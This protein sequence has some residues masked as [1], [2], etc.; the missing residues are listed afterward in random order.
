MRSWLPPLAVLLLLAGCAKPQPSAYVGGAA[1]AGTE[2]VSLGT[3][4]SGE[5]CNQLPGNAPDT[6]AV[7]CGTWQQPAATILSDGAYG[8]A[9]PMNVATSGT[10][11]DTIDLRFACDAPVAASILGDAQAAV[12]QC[13]RRI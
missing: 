8:T 11:R 13:R 10:W 2:G 9:S 1:A 3:N 4:A 7:F 5:N 12:L 6:V